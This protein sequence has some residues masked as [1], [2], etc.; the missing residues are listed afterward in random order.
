VIVRDGELV[1][2]RGEEQLRAGDRVIVLAER[3]RVG[4]VERAL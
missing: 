2:P 1:F 4:E 3:R